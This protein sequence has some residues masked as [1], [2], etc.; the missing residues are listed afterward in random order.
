M[1]D[2]SLRTKLA[3]N[4]IARISALVATAWAV[5]L[6]APNASAQVKSNIKIEHFIYII[7]ENHSFDSYFGTFPGANGIPA[8]TM[9]ADTP[10]GPLTEKP[11]HL[12]ADNI[13]DDLNHNWNAAHTAM[14]GGQMDGFMWSEWP[15]GLR[16]WGGQVPPPTQ[17]QAGVKSNALPKRSSNKNSPD[18][19]RLSPNGFADDEDEDDQTVEE[20]N[21]ARMATL[22]THSPPL[23]KDRPSWVIYTLAY[24][25]YNEIPNYWQYAM[26]FTLCDN[27]FCSLAG[28]SE[29]NHLYAL[30]AQSGGTYKPAPP[31]SINYYSFP[32]M[33]EL[34]LNSGVTWS[35]Y[36]GTNPQGP[37]QWKPL[38][39]FTQYHN[40]PTLDSHL[41]LTKQF[42]KDL[43]D[44]TLPQV[45]WI[46]PAHGVSEHP[47]EDVP[48]GMWYVTGL[49][50]A[51]MQSPY[52]NSCAII[53][54]WD[55]WG[56]LYDHVPPPQVDKYGYGP[57]VPAIVISPYCV[58]G[59]VN[60]TQFDLTSPL[61]L[62]ETAFGLSPLTSRDAN[63]NNMLDG[64]NFSQTPLPPVI[65][66]PNTKLDF[67]HL[68]PTTP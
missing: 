26:T 29:P 30:A 52:W 36:S 51:V 10:G 68:V 35:F 38:P 24:M 18:Q 15:A 14:D 60:H 56:G 27:F 37:S 40:N 6:L 7:Q 31:Q 46:V 33:G 20:R 13:P 2:L 64:F 41:V 61:K 9:L 21:D 17:T 19:R 59:V 12:T 48:R 67:N 1:N 57:R 34:L 55:D 66:T 4:S 44:G 58:S 22:G 43:T 8:G 23:V 63:S 16:Y 47:P 28:P 53:L 42:Y 11:F 32:T 62:I 39:S 50:N 54:V 45:S 65:I 25:D 5:A 49:V 3:I